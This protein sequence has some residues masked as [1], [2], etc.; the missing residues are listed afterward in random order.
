MTELERIKQSHKSQMER[1]NESRHLVMYNMHPYDVD[2]LI[3]QAERVDSLLEKT[4]HNFEVN[5]KIDAENQRYKQA[6][7]EI[8]KEETVTTALSDGQV[9]YTMSGHIARKALEGDSSE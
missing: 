5:R 4:G 9:A 8:T 2:W 1:I 6:L 7:E 3:Q